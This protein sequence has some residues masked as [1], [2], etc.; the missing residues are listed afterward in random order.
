MAEVEMIMDLDDEDKKLLREI[1]RFTIALGLYH[2][3]GLTKHG[4]V[5]AW[6]GNG[7]GQLGIGSKEVKK[8]KLNVN[9]L[10]VELKK[11]LPKAAKK[12]QQAYHDE[13][14]KDM[15][16]YELKQALAEVAPKEFQEN[17]MVSKP[18]KD[19]ADTPQ[20]VKFPSKYSST[21]RIVEVQAGLKHSVALDT[22]GQVYSWGNGA[23]GKLG[24]GDED[25]RHH[26]T[27]VE[28]IA[29]KKVIRI[30]CGSDCSACLNDSGEIYTWGVGRYG[31][32]GHGT[33]NVE[34]V[35]RV[36]DALI[37]KKMIYLSL[38]SKHT[39][40]LEKGE[41]KGDGNLVW[42]WGSGSD[43]RLG[44]SSDAG[45]F[46]PVMLTALKDE[47]V[48]HISAGETHTLAISRSGSI[49]SWGSGDYG[50]L[51]HGDT[52]TV[53]APKL[54]DELKHVKVRLCSAGSFHSLAISQ[55]GQLFAWGGGSYGK[56]GHG[57]NI[58]QIIPREVDKIESVIAL[59]AT[60]F[61]SAI[62][63]SVSNM[64]LCGY[65]GNG[66]LGNGS[67]ASV[68]VFSLL[69]NLKN[70]I[71]VES[72]KVEAVTAK[73]EITLMDVMQTREIVSAALGGFHSIIVTDQGLIYAF[74]DGRCGQLGINMEGLK[75][76]EKR[77]KL[78]PKLVPGLTNA[79]AVASGTNHTLSI[80]KDG[81]IWSWGRGQGGVLGHG[82][83]T[84]QVEPRMLRTLSHKTVVNCSASEMHS[85]CCTDE[86]ELWTWGTSD[87]GKL[88][89]GELNDETTPRMVTA[90][91]GKKVI[92]VACGFSHTVC[93]VDSTRD[94]Y[95]WGSGN[96]GKLGTG[97]QINRYEPTLI[98]GLKRRNIK[99]IRSGAF[100]TLALSDKGNVYSW[101]ANDLGQIGRRPMPEFEPGLIE[102]LR[103]V[104]VKMIACG[105]G[106]AMVLTEGNEVYSWGN[107]AYG[108]LG[109]GNRDAEKL[110]KRIDFL[111]E[112]EIKTIAC[113]SNH[114]MV[115]TAD[116]Q[117][118]VWGNGANGRLGLGSI[119][120]QL[121]PVVCHAMASA[122]K[123]SGGVGPQML[124]DL[125][126]TNIPLER[127]SQ[128]LQKGKAL[129][130]RI[131]DKLDAN[132]SVDMQDELSGMS[133][134]EDANM[135]E[136]MILVRAA[137]LASG[138]E[139]AT[140]VSL[141]QLVKS[142]AKDV[143]LELEE[144]Q[145]KIEGLRF[146]LDK[147]VRRN[148]QAEM[149]GNQLNF[150]IGN[151]IRNQLQLQQKLSSS[152]GYVRGELKYLGQSDDPLLQLPME[153][154]ARM[155]NILYEKPS[156]LMFLAES[157]PES[158]NQD[159]ERFWRIVMFTLYGDQA[160][161]RDEF[162]LLSLAHQ[163]F[164]ERGS[165]VPN[166]SDLLE[167]TENVGILIQQ[168]TKRNSCLSAAK[169]IL[170][171]VIKE[172]MEK[173][174][175][176][177]VDPIVVYAKV[178][179]KA[180]GSDIVYATAAQDPSVKDIIHGHSK[181]LE[182]YLEKLVKRITSTH[183]ILPFGV[184]WLAKRLSEIAEEKLPPGKDVPAKL[185]SLVCRFIGSRIFYQG[186]IQ[187]EWLEICPEPPSADVKANLVLLMNS[188]DRVLT[189][190]Y[191]KEPHL[192]FLN[193]IIRNSQD[194]LVSYTEFITT[195]K[196]LELHNRESRYIQTLSP[197]TPIISVSI[198]DMDFLHTLID[199]GSR[200]GH[201]PGDQKEW[202]KILSRAGVVH[203][204][205]EPQLNSTINIRL[206]L[207]DRVIWPESEQPLELSEDKD[208]K[209][210]L[211][212]ALQLMPVLPLSVSGTLPENLEKA[213]LEATKIEVFPAAD[214]LQA[215]L[216][217]VR[218]KQTKVEKDDKAW[219]DKFLKDTAAQIRILARLRN[220]LKQEYSTLQEMESELK[221]H[222]M[223]LQQQLDRAKQYL[224]NVKHNKITNKNVRLG[225]RKKQSKDDYVRPEVKKKMDQIE[226]TLLV[227]T[228]LKDDHRQ[229]M[230]NDLRAFIE[231]R[232]ESL[233][234]IELG[235]EVD[236]NPEWTKQFEE[237]PRLMEL[238]GRT[239][240]LE[241]MIRQD[242]DLLAL[243]DLN[244]KFAEMLLSNGDLTPNDLKD[245]LL[246]YPELNEFMAENDSLRQLLETRAVLYQKNKVVGDNGIDEIEMGPLCI[247]KYEKAVKDG[248]IVSM[249]YPE[250][251]LSKTSLQ[252]SSSLRGSVDIL[253]FE[254]K[255]HKAIGHFSVTKEDLIDCLGADKK[256]IVVGRVKFNVEALLNFIDMNLRW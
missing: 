21:Y 199:Q 237:N 158:N 249:E 169:K 81:K 207:S 48:V 171:P 254:R 56:L 213:K 159:R 57:D 62:V 193:K 60:T 82:D 174:Q 164:I 142:E 221:L 129:S 255:K 185:T 115:V 23:N 220:M 152:E 117:L 127:M 192:M 148:D 128:Y 68:N 86:G 167:R 210:Q 166:A 140:L 151:V 9:Q 24:H 2:T 170:S 182:N 5:F 234:K 161:A 149:M 163:L 72:A 51:G 114:S 121:Q 14:I 42:A 98:I 248:V 34:M 131:Q 219:N 7:N 229:L 227:R 61:H 28:A 173:G 204:D 52:A 165:K 19:D 22:L 212:I 43:G 122:L 64:Y 224:K 145:K 156:V 39:V 12:F 110:P 18:P 85:A 247:V 70:E 232:L 92:Q 107:N 47:D 13:K 44:R 26:P 228:V 177:E 97:D 53:F 201:L 138:T 87:F 250:K 120:V 104:K 244:P 223:Q 54:I 124:S 186:I 236:L 180:E 230:S 239:P 6:G 63:T 211:L 216:A 178:H 3:L 80:S 197:L 8:K 187:P 30:A 242:K 209:T 67:S 175:L 214:K 101:G 168:Y 93:L 69:R 100:F 188:L 240:T 231:Q 176:L 123:E 17:S 253:A 191:S 58:N 65:G 226:A 135:R 35:P 40:S 27:L 203:G 241:S 11:R 84:D 246:Q 215:V 78:E 235:E 71:M 189:G 136:N 106:H 46:R 109:H 73:G 112:H 137:A 243:F 153:E 38:G 133:M 108:Q 126:G 157:I 146:E 205:V 32:L 179:P 55:Q 251:I 238:I 198:N 59:K 83:V 90:M 25:D 49:F 144:E 222:G 181:T 41:N 141:Q 45:E 184:R 202:L 50:K 66:R 4:Q 256:F 218:S 20:L 245:F 79:K 195:V 119:D 147:I 75:R 160:K 96:K 36:V 116:G 102:E 233:R 143:H 139:P 252:F 150:K 88:G 125:Q 74:G 33:N 91:D 155:L 37:G 118:L 190:N 130:R 162:N 183:S 103:S 111:L 172:F 1:P 154:Y 225:K 95:A 132:Q 113:G 196:S 29:R 76:N 10:R 134:G 217:F 105:E 208:I 94:V 89:H 200:S 77:E 15:T 206:R 31:N 99:E 194:L 16:V